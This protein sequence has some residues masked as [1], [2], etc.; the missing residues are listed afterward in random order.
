MDRIRRIFVV[1]VIAII[2]FTLVGIRTAWLMVLARIVL[3]PVIATFSYEIIYFGSRHVDNPVVRVVLYPGLWL[4]SLTTR[5]PD[6]DQLEVAMTALRK[7]L[8]SDQIEE[9][10][11]AAS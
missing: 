10:P 11:Q 2:V 9:A 8:E 1:L 4:Q 6:D 7:V 5:E 3:I